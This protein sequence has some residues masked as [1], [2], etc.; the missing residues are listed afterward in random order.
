MNYITHIMWSKGIGVKESLFGK[1][2]E[3]TVV[4][5]DGK[6]L[7]PNVYMITREQAKK[8]KREEINTGLMGV[9]IP[10]IDIEQYIVR[11]I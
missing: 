10:R 8:Y 9:F 4:S 7:H 3:V 11:D 5:K 2:F 1:E 6:R